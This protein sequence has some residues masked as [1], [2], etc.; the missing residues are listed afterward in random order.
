MFA[1]LANYAMCFAM[2]VIWIRKVLPVWTLT[3][4][5]QS[6]IMKIKLFLRSLVIPHQFRVRQPKK[7]NKK[8]RK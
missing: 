8:T 6:V 7:M 5:T 2:D 3:L 4:Y 1:Q